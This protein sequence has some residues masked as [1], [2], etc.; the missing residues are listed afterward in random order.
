MMPKFIRMFGVIRQDYVM[1]IMRIGGVALGALFIFAG[2][3]HTHPGLV[4]CL[5]LQQSNHCVKVPL[6][7]QVVAAQARALAPLPEG[8]AAIYLLRTYAQQP[9][10]ASQVFV[11]DRLEAT[12]GPKTFARIVV[13]QGQH[14]VRIETGGMTSLAYDVTSVANVYL[15]YQLIETLMAR[16]QKIAELSE[17][18]AETQMAHLNMV[19]SIRTLP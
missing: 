13:E 17:S 3:T 1:R 10:A 4:H 11:D 2:C 6:E 12:L 18:Q 19:K 16:H 7:D 15:Q 14:R 8:K 9:K 5:I